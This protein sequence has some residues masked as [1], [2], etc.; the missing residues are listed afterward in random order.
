MVGVTFGFVVL[1]ENIPS[2]GERN[3]TGF[4][5]NSIQGLVGSEFVQGFCQGFLEG[6]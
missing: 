4:G 6:R 2:R 5:S 3:N 1:V